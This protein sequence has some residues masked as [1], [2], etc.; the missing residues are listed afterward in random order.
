[1]ILLCMR[2]AQLSYTSI[3]YLSVAAAL[4]SKKNN[5]FICAYGA[6]LH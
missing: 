2:G 5:Y 4:D 3:G 1:M 6:K